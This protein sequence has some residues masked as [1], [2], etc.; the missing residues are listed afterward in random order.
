ISMGFW[1]GRPSGWHA[2]EALRRAWQS[3]DD[4]EST[5]RSMMLVTAVVVTFATAVSA[6]PP[7]SLLSGSAKDEL[8]GNLRGLLLKNLPQPL[9]Q[10]ENNWGHQEMVRRR[11]VAGKL[12]DLHVE[13]THEP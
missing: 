10:K 12:G 3:P 2:P 4:M 6:A 5:M 1:A 7:V 11:H 9:Y 13:V 8:A